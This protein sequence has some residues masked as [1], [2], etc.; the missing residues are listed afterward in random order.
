MS[1]LEDT[2]SASSTSSFEE[3]A[4]VKQDKMPNITVEHLRT[5]CQGCVDNALIEWAM[6][7]PQRKC[8]F[9]QAV[10]IAMSKNNLWQHS[11]DTL[12]EE[13]ACHPP[14]HEEFGI[15]NDMFTFNQVDERHG[16][17]VHQVFT[18]QKCTPTIVVSRSLIAPQC[19][20]IAQLVS[21]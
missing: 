10:K 9:I 3:M 2:D 14:T 13:L 7:T 1:N 8:N 6:V 11:E 21:R 20:A 5:M 17:N 15:P 4:L 18:I 12:M 19:A 16:D